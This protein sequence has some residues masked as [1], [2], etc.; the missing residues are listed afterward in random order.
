MVLQLTLLGYLLVP[1]VEWGAWWLVLLTMAAMLTINSLEA[2]SRPAH[3]YK[4]PRTVQGFAVCTVLPT[5][6]TACPLLFVTASNQPGHGLAL[7]LS[8]V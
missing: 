8:C 6:S 4:V 1:V 7:V 2:V 3:T 5:H